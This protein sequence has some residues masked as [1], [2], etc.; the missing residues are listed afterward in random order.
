[1]DV[2]EQFVAHANVDVL[3]RLQRQISAR[4]KDL[5]LGTPDLIQANQ[6]IPADATAGRTLL[7][8]ASFC[9]EAQ[10]D[11]ILSQTSLVEYHIA[12]TLPDGGG[13]RRSYGHMLQ[14]PVQKLVFYKFVRQ[15]GRAVGPN[16]KVVIPLQITEKGERAVNFMQDNAQQAAD[17]AVVPDEDEDLLAWA[18]NYFEMQAEMAG[19]Y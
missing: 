10:T 6:N 15:L 1:M 16:G 4:M 19:H 8:M 9:R 13:N 14:A 2:A 11:V 18:E 17:L 7:L 12:T 5:K 3:R